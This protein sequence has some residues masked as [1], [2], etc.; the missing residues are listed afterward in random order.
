MQPLPPAI[1]AVMFV[2]GGVFTVGVLIAAVL[3]IRFTSI[4]LVCVAVG[5]LTFAVSQLVIRLPLVSLV[6]LT[7]TD[8]VAEHA[9]IWLTLLAVTAGLVEEP[10]RAL[11]FRL[12]LQREPDRLATPVGLGIGHGGFEAVALVGFSQLA[13]AVTFI[14]LSA[15]SSVPPP[16]VLA[17]RD[18]LVSLDVIG[19]LAGPYER[20][21][22]IALHITLSV[23]VFRAVRDRRWLLL[24][25][26]VL[27]HGIVNFVTVASARW[28][29]TESSGAVWLTELVMT[30]AVGL[31][32]LLVWTRFRRPAR[33]SR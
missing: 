8:W 1:L 13:T 14:V 29:G 5:I 20:I 2:S 4:R 25:L 22:A 24:V 21:P 27:L 31:T 10:A 3:I 16:E 15:T 18:A 32:A 28:F 7:A 6:Q 30:G 9:W 11:G 23:L 12:L 19:A 17:Q 33:I 26:A